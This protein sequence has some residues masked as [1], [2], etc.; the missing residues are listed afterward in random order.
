[1]MGVRFIPGVAALGGTGGA[2]LSELFTGR[3]YA[4]L[5]DCG[6][7][8]DVLE[9]WGVEL[10]V[11]ERV[12]FLSHTKMLGSVVV[13]KVTGLPWASSSSMYRGVLTR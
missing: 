1:M 6:V 2:L 4:F 5:W 13:I 12:V 8:V 11:V 7:E 3:V 9:D 10:A